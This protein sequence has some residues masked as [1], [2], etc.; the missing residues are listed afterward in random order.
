MSLAYR[1]PKV[2][3]PYKPQRYRIGLD[4]GTTSTSGVFQRVSAADLN[5]VD[6]L[7]DKVHPFRRYRRTTGLG[8]QWAS[9]EISSDIQ[10]DDHGFKTGYE[11]SED[12]WYPCVVLSH[13]KLA[14]SQAEPFAEERARIELDVL[15]IPTPLPTD[16]RPGQDGAFANGHRRVRTPVMIVEDYLTRLFEHWKKELLEIGYDERDILELHCAVPA[17]WES[18]EPINQME[19]AIKNASARSALRFQ[20]V[21]RFWPEPEAA[22]AHLLHHSPNIG[23]L[24]RIAFK[25]CDIGANT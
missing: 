4:Y 18:T 2:E 10:Y 16:E 23:L 20:E 25:T 24:V 21:I 19:S 3:E 13:V 9:S 7:G 5:R 15:S 8:K 14:L 11:V 22:T 6:L 17:A 1:L 12:P